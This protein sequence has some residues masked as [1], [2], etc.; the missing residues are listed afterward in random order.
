MHEI[1]SL[2]LNHWYFEIGNHILYLTILNKYTFP[3]EEFLWLI[4][5]M[6]TIAILHEYFAD[7]LA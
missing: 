2:E 7:D 1:T 4:Q 3:L 5:V 6:P